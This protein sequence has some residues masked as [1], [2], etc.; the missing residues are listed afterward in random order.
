VLAGGEE[1]LADAVACLD[2]LCELGEYRFNWS[3]GESHQ[4]GLAE[5]LDR[6]AMADFLAA[7][8]AS[9]NSGDVYAQLVTP[10]H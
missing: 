2:R 10:I 3:P 1:A 9:A 7:L 4:L 6:Q 5:W 8:P